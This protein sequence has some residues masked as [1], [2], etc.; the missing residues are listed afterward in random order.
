MASITPPLP[1]LSPD[2]A[3]YHTTDP[4]L[5]N[6]PLLIFH[7][8]AASL[9]STSSRIQIH[10][11]TP[12][13]LATYSRLAV[14]PTSPF[15][16]AVHNLPREEQ[17]DEVC[18]G[19]AFGLKK[20]FVEL[21]GGVKTAWQ[22]TSRTPV[23]ALWGDD[24]VAILASRITKVENVEAVKQALMRVFGEQRVPW[25]DVDVV[26][27]P[28]S[29]K[30][31][32]ERGEAVDE[33]EEMRCRYGVYAELVAA[34]GEPS[35]LPTSKLKRAPSKANSVGRGASFTAKQRETAAKELNELLET[36]RNYVSRLTEAVALVGELESQVDT[37][38]FQQLR[39]IFPQT[40]D[41]MLQL[42]EAFLADLH[43]AGDVTDGIANEQQIVV[44]ASYCQQW[45]PRFAEAYSAY[46]RT[47]S[48]AAQQLKSLLRSDSS[49]ASKL[50]DVG[51]QQLTSLLI[52][53]VQRLP[54][55]NLYIDGITKQ[56]PTRHP[57]L[58]P[59]MAARDTISDICTADGE[60]GS[61]TMSVND[62]IRSCV[63][64][65]PEDAQ[66]TGR[67]ITAVDATELAPPF[68]MDRNLS[69]PL[70]LLL[71]TD[72]IVFLERPTSTGCA[73]SL[74][75]EL[76]GKPSLQRPG[77]PNRPAFQRRVRLSALEATSVLEDRALQLATYSPLPAIGQ[78]AP[79]VDDIQ[80]LLLDGSYSGKAGRLLEELAKTR[81]EDR[82]TEEE[83]ESHKWDVR[84][85]P[86]T[87]EQLGLL[88]AVL[89]EPLR[90][91]THGAVRIVLD[92]DKHSHRPRAGTN[93]IRTVF[94]VALQKGGACRLSID[95]VEGA[96]GYDLVSNVDVVPYICRKLALL[97]ASHFSF[98]SPAM[99][100]A[101]LEYVADALQSIDLS[102][103]T[104]EATAVPKVPT[105]EDS[106]RY[107]PKSPVK[108]L[109]SF[110]ASAGPGSQAP[111]IKKDLPSL[112]TPR[113]PP[114][115][116]I[117]T[118]S[119]PPSRESRPMSKESRPPMSVHSMRSTE[120]LPSSQAVNTHKRLEDT[121]ST[122]MLALQ[123]R[124]G[125][126]VGRHLK[127]RASAEPLAVSELY[128]GLL[129]DPNMMVLAAEA[130][131]DV[132]FVAFEKFLNS[133]WKDQVGPVISHT[134]LQEVQ[135]QAET[136]FPIDFD[137]Y[138]RAALATLSPQNQ[139]AF[140]GIMTLLADLLDGTGNDGDRGILTAAFAELLVKNGNPRDFIALIDR[141]VEDTDTYFGEPLSEAQ[142]QADVTASGHKRSR[143][144]TNTGSVGSNT[145][146]LRRKFGFGGLSREN[147]KSEQDS[148]MTSVWR[149]LSKSTRGESPG[150][151]ISRGTLHRSQ[152]TD[153]DG[154][155]PAR[156]LSQDGAALRKQPSLDEAAPLSSQS[157]ALNAGLS[158]IGEHPCLI[159]K[160][161]PPKK[162][163]RSSLSD[164]KAL[165]ATQKSPAWSP[166]AQRRQLPVAS[167]FSTID[168]SLPNSP[169]PST[170]SSRGGSGRFGTPLPGS[171]R[172]RLP[173]S[174]RKENEP[175][176]KALSY[177]PDRAA[178]SPRPKTSAGAPTDPSI[179]PLRQ[180]SNIPTLG[181]VKAS[182]S[183]H[184]INTIR[185]GLSER[186]G[187]ANIIKKP[188]PEPEKAKASTLGVQP[189]TL[190]APPLPTKKLKV[191]SPV[192]LKE[193]VGSLQN[194]LDRIG[195]ELGTGSNA[196]NVEVA[197][198]VAALATKVEEL[199]SLVTGS[200]TIS[201]AKS[202]NLDTLYR[203]ANSENEALYARFNDE[204]GRIFKAV[205]ATP[206]SAGAGG[207][208]ELKKQLREAQE[209]SGK[210]R[211]ENA[212]LKREGAGLRAQ[213]RD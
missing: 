116:Y 76:E 10:I 174:F 49:L 78:A 120:T 109:S 80:I 135:A 34:L 125:N 168:K 212:R 104:E 150:G 50:S 106:Q 91:R 17:G 196:K 36:E 156:P 169:M 139:R 97:T 5:S 113:M 24:H 66:L 42:N 20:Y 193:R 173:V 15:Y 40:V 86:P 100:R 134:L 202:R 69:T 37:A 198:Q 201:E 179:S 33:D 55:Y 3:L 101:L 94:A 62:R 129:E 132:L 188:S 27:P 64:G 160:S 127:L 180:I 96:A 32:V 124:K 11:F 22:G 81:V 79:T 19:V 23:S 197:K 162:K 204:M 138:F 186:P 206:G 155:L 13:G 4:L 85:N 130:P 30:A 176:S 143:S 163:R 77:T 164:I 171:P 203:E 75:T 35:F 72:S 108:M 157:S 51:E 151:S 210:L 136:L 192:K 114:P 121:L 102:I 12:A 148:K 110:L 131:V 170:P 83:R 74:L 90:T 92:L 175:P 31:L 6:S 115:Q 57:A 1:H 190:T 47:H 45:F 14:A 70:T 59:F 207:V 89:E 213:L 61:S 200:L 183:P 41:M 105:R 82:F 119:K 185:S 98:A 26:L 159:P 126:I 153:M 48:A 133:A 99:T 149:S 18:R 87:S 177:S 184:R 181:S 68:D 166:P 209:E 161:G 172:P 46:M 39:A 118:A 63:F 199:R 145:S 165:A 38:D 137:R 152:S 144:V 122:Y 205:Q 67:L 147:S 182:A 43:K 189:M 111:S 208:E 71:F 117:P 140:K 146:S 7:G 58:K 16:S 56:L 191:Q 25:V 93:G 142:A 65:W 8:P 123:A 88:S 28:G 194:E 9:S 29:I 154:R 60:D 2:L 54:R 73:R 112:P 21:D 95:S 107:R 44:I 141:F 167:P 103:H 158:T 211:R 84:A 128:N 53:P 195:E 187:L 178:D 52:E